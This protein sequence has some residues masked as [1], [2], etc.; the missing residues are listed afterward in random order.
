MLAYVFSHR[1]AAGADIAVYEDLMRRFHGALAGSP[2][3]GFVRS[4]TFRAAGGYVDWYLIE[5]SAALDALNQAAIS[6]RRSRPHDAV[7]QMAAE[8]SG[9]LMTLTLGPPDLQAGFEVR[10]SKPKGVSYA[11]LDSLLEPSTRQAGVS[12]WKRMMVLGPPPEFSLLTPMHLELPAETSPQL[13]P[14]EAL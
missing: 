4:V 3:P 13:L 1:A 11:G 6:G 9:K 14:L 8:G 2:P 5:G 10:F 7:A 12:V